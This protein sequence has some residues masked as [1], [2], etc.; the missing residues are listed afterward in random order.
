M[1]RVAFMWGSVCLNEAGTS[2][3]RKY[4]GL[5][6]ESSSTVKGAADEWQVITR[7]LEESWWFTTQPSPGRMADV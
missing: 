3:T 6:H 2:M 1:E 4:T 5:M 7:V